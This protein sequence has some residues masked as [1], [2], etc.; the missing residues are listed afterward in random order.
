MY[1]E[2]R[3]LPVVEVLQRHLLVVEVNETLQKNLLTE[4]VCHEHLL[5]VDVNQTLQFLKFLNVE[6]HCLRLWTDGVGQY[7]LN[8]EEQVHLLAERNL[9]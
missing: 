5:I 7:L 9:G 6:M 8:V 3:N 2:P 1:F 4:V